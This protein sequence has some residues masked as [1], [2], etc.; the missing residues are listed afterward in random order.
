[1]VASFLFALTGGMLLILSTARVQQIAWNFLRLIGFVSFG[2]AC[3]MTFWSIKRGPDLNDVVSA[4]AFRSG[5]A[6]AAG[7]FV[8]VFA[9]GMAGSRP[10]LVRA[11]CFAGG[12]AGLTASCLLVE[13][14]INDGAVSSLAIGLTLFGQVLG[15]LLLGSITIAWLLGH[16]YLTA[17]KMTIAP[18]LHFS[19]LLLWA[20]AV[21]FL[22]LVGVVGLPIL[23]GSTAGAPSQEALFGSWILLIL[24]VG[25]GLIAVGA[26]AY[27]VADCVRIRAT[28]SA[29]GILYF[30]SVFAYV[31]ELTAQHLSLQF[32]WPL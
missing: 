28:Q 20:V 12:V 1:M 6:S 17:T 4:W 31:G 19:R 30:G 27:M 13:A 15:S 18:L 10:G 9:A 11:I 26:F 8:L 25:V 24:R 2:V 16:A 21:R 14:R 23:I 7:S 29:T 5:I 3:L 22:F 32:A